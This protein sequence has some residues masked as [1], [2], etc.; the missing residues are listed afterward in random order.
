VKDFLTRV[1]ERALGTAPRIDP[2]ATSRYA[3]ARLPL[4]E[5]HSPLP[6]KPARVGS[7]PRRSRAP[8][9][10]REI[11]TSLEPAREVAEKINPPEQPRRKNSLV[12][13]PAIP[14]I[15]LDTEV[16]S[17]P[18]RIRTPFVVNGPVP[19]PHE[20]EN[21]PTPV[22]SRHAPSVDH[23]SD[24]VE[25]P[26]IPD[27]RNESVPVRGAS[28]ADN[29]HQDQRPKTPRLNIVKPIV[30]ESNRIAESVESS[31]A[32]PV[33]IV[34]EKSAKVSPPREHQQPARAA[35]SPIVASPTVTS[36]RGPHERPERREKTI[37]VKIG[38]V[39]VHAPPAPVTPV[40]PPAAPG[41]KVS[42]AEFLRQHNRRRDE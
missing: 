25:T 20:I 3:P 29:K 34:V 30:D 22:F 16:A 24:E 8:Q 28:S 13:K 12:R 35:V 14:P 23:V 19:E 17:A 32:P 5:S 36:D 4:P 15:E 21:H 37:Q 41:P 11:V 6:E 1:A 10:D 2:Q 42:L 31:P 26:E 27:P 9:A 33:E 39:E 40:E 18:E 38:R 7:P